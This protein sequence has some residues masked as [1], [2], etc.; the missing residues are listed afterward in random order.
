[1]KNIEQT[2]SDLL[3]IFSA[4][5]E[6]VGGTSAVKRE[7]LTNSDQYSDQFHV[8]AIG[9]A[10]DAMLQGIIETET[11]KNKRI[12]TALL[13]SKHDHISD[14]M[15]N[16]PRVHSIESDHPL[17]KEATMKAGE[18]LLDYVSHL[19]KDETCVFLI[20]GGASSLVEVLNDG[21]DL[22]QLQELTDYLLANGYNINQMN[23][24]RR[25]ISKI[26]GGGLWQFVGNRPVHCLMISDVP[27]D[28]P[29][30][31][32]SGVLFPVDDIELPDLPEQFTKK[33]PTFQQQKQS[34]SFA[35]KIIASLDVAKT[36]AAKKAT[37]LGY[38]VEIQDDFLDGEA[39]EVAKSCIKSSQDKTNTLFIWG[40]ETMVYLP[41]NPGAGGRNQHLA[42]SA[43]IAIENHSKVV[44]L[45]AG[46]DGSDGVSD[47]TGAIVDGETVKRGLE[48]S[49]N[50]EDYIKASDSNTYLNATG[51]TIVT[52]A[53]G[54]N[55][56]DLVLAITST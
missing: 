16:D 53:T 43:A 10:S 13:I 49:L 35:W 51:D 33:I 27:G 20:S 44:L 50:A 39:S 5:V 36:S 31:I 11:A 21:W 12:K 7:F 26:K 18:L 47:A 32:G 48:T 14:K 19:P 37:E 3:A 23:A 17:P 52:G 2:R 46:T 42:L 38:K 29:S 28:S 41:E 15:Q 22:E 56:M 34:A 4:A 30:D 24:I 54:T 25:R 1:M 40:G 8:V 6:A 55:V 45:A 9:K